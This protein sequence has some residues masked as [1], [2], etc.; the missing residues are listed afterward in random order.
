MY[1]RSVASVLFL[2]LIVLTVQAA[3]GEAAAGEAAAAK[4]G[5]VRVLVITGGHD[6]EQAPFYG[7]FEAME[8]V[9][10]TKATYPDAAS[11]LTPDLADTCDVV[12]FYDMWAQGISDTQQQAFVKLLE[13]GIGVVAL[14]HTLAAHQNWPEYARIIGGKFHLQRQEGDK[15]VPG[16][17]YFHDQEVNVRVANSSHPITRG[18]SDF[19]IRDETYNNY[20]TDPKAEVLLTTEHPKS[21]RELAWVKT[22]AKSRVVYVAL[23]HDHFAYEN[24][25]FRTVV[26]RSILWAAGRL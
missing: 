24:P 23:G 6:F 12:V 9:T 13:R 18:L 15:V 5:K 22:Y 20:D 14:H 16:S 11:L 2:S 3:A 8:G 10:M 17:G 25:N 1:H 7:M 19:Q 21:D 4:G 26:A